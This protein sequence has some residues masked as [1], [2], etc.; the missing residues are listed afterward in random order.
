MGSLDSYKIIEG[1][2]D[3]AD[4]YREF[5]QRAYQRAYVKPELGITEDL[6]S[7]SVFETDTVKD[8]FKG[9]CSNT[10]D[11]KIWFAVD[12]NNCILG[13]LGV[14]RFPNYCEMRAFYVDPDYKGS[15]I[16]HALFS[17]VQAFSTGSEIRADVI[18][19][20]QDTINI[21]VHW[22][23]HVDESLGKVT[24]PRKDWPVAAREAYK[25]IFLVRPSI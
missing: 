6:F 15:G 22:G 10:H 18:E 9:L 11:E 20:M 4:K 13:G 7:K 21:Y 1:T 3:W 2:I 23:F 16:G 25:G 14:K 19:Y 8:Y 24:Y 5:C 17:K 12:K